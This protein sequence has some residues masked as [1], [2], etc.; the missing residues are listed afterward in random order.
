MIDLSC[1]SPQCFNIRHPE[2]GIQTRKTKKKG[3]NLH[4]IMA[5][6]KQEASE[7]GDLVLLSEPTTA[8]FAGQIHRE[9]TPFESLDS[10]ES[11]FFPDSASETE[12]REIRTPVPLPTSKG[13]AARE[14]LGDGMSL[15]DSADQVDSND[16]IDSVL[17]SITPDIPT[18]VELVITPQNRDRDR[19]Q[20]DKNDRL[21]KTLTPTQE[22]SQLEIEDPLAAQGHY[23]KRSGTYRKSKP[24]L[25]P[26]PKP[27]DELNSSNREGKSDYLQRSGTYK[28]DKE[29]S[30]GEQQ[31][32]LP[33][34]ET[35]D[36]LQ[37]SGT[38]R[39]KRPSLEHTAGEHQLELPLQ[40]SEEA[41]G[42][43]QR[44]GTYT[45]KG[46]A[47]GGHQLELPSN[48]TGDYLQRSG[49]YKKTRPSLEITA[50]EQQLEMPANDGEE[51]D[52]LKRSGTYRKKKPSLASTPTA[53]TTQQSGDHPRTLCLS[54]LSQD[55]MATLQSSAEHL[56][57]SN[58]IDS[59]MVATSLVT[60]GAD[61]VSVDEGEGEGEG[62]IR[63]RRSG[64]FRKER[65]TLASSPEIQPSEPEDREATPTPG[66]VSMTT[67]ALPGSVYWEGE[68]VAVGE[69]GEPDH[70]LSSHFG[71][72]YF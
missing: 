24:S 70:P 13:A 15:H 60:L 3:D 56:T 12:E 9:S 25:S 26:V 38:Y 55:Y 29:P 37:R 2:K 4:C 11:D 43:L 19:H 45:K 8:P 32:E 36:Y 66:S 68:S 17:D 44:S 39:K 1:E 41:G 47:A 65:P 7:W 30:L 64:T 67:L 31:L 6:Q 33:C 53:S 27:D 58:D 22:T 20:L 16:Q 72:E 61:G 59:T 42:H 34:D 54:S 46:H 23:T 35:G 49:T 63:V 48:E 69:D 14:R 40:G 5:F 18:V 28:K 71:D 62:L 52:Y 50:G 51:E 21:D 57:D 10:S